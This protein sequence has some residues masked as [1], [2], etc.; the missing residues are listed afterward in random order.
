MYPWI[1]IVISEVTLSFLPLVFFPASHLR[2]FPLLFYP[3]VFPRYTAPGRSLHIPRQMDPGPITP[4][5]RTQNAAPALGWQGK[6]LTHP[7][8]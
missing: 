2:I 4:N 6:A 7:P 1:S 3:P 5:E 8:R